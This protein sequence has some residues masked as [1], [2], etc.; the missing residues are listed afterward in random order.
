LPADV[1]SQEV[2]LTG[3]QDRSE[4]DEIACGRAIIQRK[5]TFSDEQCESHHILSGSASGTAL[6]MG[7]KTQIETALLIEKG[8]RVDATRSSKY[9]SLQRHTRLRSNRYGNFC[10]LK[11]P[12]I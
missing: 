11:R 2:F 12:P 10:L 7:A 1:E 4:I 6:N 8:V 3:K 5:T 9:R